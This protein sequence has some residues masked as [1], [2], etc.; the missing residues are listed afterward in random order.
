METNENEDPR[1]HEDLDLLALLI[2]ATALA[3]SE[4]SGDILVADFESETHGD[5]QVTGEAIEIGFSV[6]TTG[7]YEL[8]V[9]FTP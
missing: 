2:A 4:P 8:M 5:W 1:T 3:Q 7:R 9:V 6:P